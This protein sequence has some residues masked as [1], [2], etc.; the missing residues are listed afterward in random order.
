MTEESP[1][2]ELMGTPGAGKS[3][4][5]GA[6]HVALLERGIPVLR[7]PGSGPEVAARSIPGVLVGRLTR[8]RLRRVLT[9]RLFALERWVRGIAT[10]LASPGLVRIVLSSQILRPSAAQTRSRRP[11]HWLIR[12]AGERSMLLSRRRAGEVV[13]VDEGFG[14][15]VVQLFTSAVE[16]ADP[17][18]VAR[19]LSTVPSPSLTINVAA[20]V[21]VCFAR[22]RSRGVWDRFAG[23]DDGLRAFLYSAAGALEMVARRYE[24]SGIRLVTIDNSAVADPGQVSERV[25]AALQ[26]AGVV[27]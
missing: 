22:I 7:S 26:T 24:E 27:T 19:Y 23:D 17:D 6:L 3:T 16:A 8:G 25:L 2:V 13:V 15:R 4:V 5:A 12:M 21:E 9:W 18:L 11:T 14:H 1:L 20:P 10:V